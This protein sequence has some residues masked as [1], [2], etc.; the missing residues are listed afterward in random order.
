MNYEGSEHVHRGQFNRFYRYNAIRS[1]GEKEN[2]YWE[3][4]FDV[5]VTAFTVEGNIMQIVQ[6][7]RL[8][9]W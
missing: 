9:F 8:I 7:L 3:G 1:R 4:L 6:I 5:R 2:A